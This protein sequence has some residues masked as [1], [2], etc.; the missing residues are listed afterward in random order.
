MTE[1]PGYTILRP[2]GRGGMATVYLARQESLG[3]EVALKVLTTRHE[4]DPTAHERF[5]REARLAASLRHPH[6]VPIFDFGLHGDLA[7]IAMEYESGG[8]VAPM[9]G[10][11]LLPR[12][13]LKIVRD[14]AAALGHAHGH[15]IVHRDIKPDNILRRDDGAAVLS[16]FGI[17][18]LVQGGPVLTAEGTSVGTPQYMSPEQLRGDKV[19]GRSDLYS[20]GVVLWQ[21]LTGELPYTGHDAWAI[22]TQH[23]T[24]EIPRLPAA[25]AHLQPLLDA[26]LAK[27]PEARV[28]TGEE[29]SQRAAAL[30]DTTATPDTTPGP[31]HATPLGGPARPRAG[32]VADRKRVAIGPAVALA[33]VGIVAVAAWFGWQASRVS[34]QGAPPAAAARGPGARAPAGP[35]S[36][37]VLSLKDLSPGHDQGYFSDGMAEE[38]QSRL[39][40][41]HGL[42]VAGSTSSQRFKDGVATL[43]QIGAALGVDNVLNGSV[44]KDGDRLRITM[45]LS[46]VHTG[47]QTWT[48]TYDRRLTDVFA[49]Q[50]EIAGAVVDALRLNLLLP[51][52]PR[53]VGARHVPEFKVY[54]MYL[55]ARQAMARNDGDWIKVSLANFREAVRLD[56][57]YA[58]AWSGLAMAESFAA[59]DGDPADAVAGNQR[60]RDAAERAV[61]LD[62]GLGDAAA[63]RG[64][65]RGRDWDW[66]GA[67]ADVRKSVELDPRD[68]RNQLRYG[69][70]LATL[71]RLPESRAALET[72]TQ[73]DPFFAP[74]WAVLARVE[75]AQGD[76][77]SS[78][79]SFDRLLAVDPK[80]LPSKRV[81]GIVAMMDGR[82]DEARRIFA[83]SAWEAGRL[84]ADY[85]QSRDEATRAA[86]RAKLVALPGPDPFEAAESLAWVGA[87]DAAFARLDALVSAHGASA[88]YI[89]YDPMLASLRSDPRYGALLARMGLPLAAD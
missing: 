77:K 22:G 11:K 26:L 65:I 64:Y 79:Q 13:A 88:A 4:D 8:T 68:G 62:P 37:A 53:P 28:Q 84:M 71:D 16:D 54:D 30:L 85:S 31:V 15:G 69:F 59:D 3:R 86:L 42:E 21:L 78:R 89:S 41:V 9:A 73:A 32:T 35:A 2:L 75:M 51:G 20:L 29:L 55:R 1:I 38:L 82:Y 47:F 14:I 49:V 67:L 7:Y 87:K 36:I 33:A 56:P 6:I 70:L 45:Q 43:A 58:D 80:F 72:G 5:L 52:A 17:A 74:L 23:I 46:N 76:Y 25:L 44:R 66:A 18:R 10:E 27:K 24:A 81:Y 50:D 34:A 83:E 63:A 48:Q 19:D 39:A 57:G 61:A 40:Q 60:A 12:E